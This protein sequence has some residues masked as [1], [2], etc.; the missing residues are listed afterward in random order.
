MGL[1][2]RAQVATEYL[3]IVGV[4]LVVVAGLTGYALFMYHEA[5]AFNQTREA[6]KDLRYAVNRVYDLGEGNS[7]IV[8][9]VLPNGVTQTRVVGKA[10]YIT[11]ARLGVTSE[12]FVETNANV[13]G[14][15]P[16]QAGI[17][18]IEVKAIDGNVSVNPT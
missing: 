16:T 6:L 1:G 14:T 13:H 17:H 3:L 7:A 5:V 12:D 15:L 18:W 2:G 10:I 4:L 9:I 11:L 8:K